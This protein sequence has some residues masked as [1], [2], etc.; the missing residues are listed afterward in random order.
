MITFW[1]LLSTIIIVFST[2]YHIKKTGFQI[3][4]PFLIFICFFLL[5]SILGETYKVKADVFSNDVYIFSSFL[6]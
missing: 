6:V 5:Y 3:W 2:Y 1:L 4:D